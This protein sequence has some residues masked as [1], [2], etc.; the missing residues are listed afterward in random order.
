[1]GTAT[2][3]LLELLAELRGTS[4]LGRTRVLARAAQVLR[5][6]PA[7]ERR[8]VATE[9]ARRVA[10]ELLP[11]VEALVEE[12]IDPGQQRM[13]LDL[14]RRLDPDAVA[15][16]AQRLLDAETGNPEEPMDIVVDV[17]AGVD[18]HAAPQPIEL[19]EELHDQL[20]SLDEPLVLAL[21]DA[22]DE[23]DGPADEPAVPVA[24]V[25]AAG[26]A[27]GLAVLPRPTRDELVPALDEEPSEP[28]VD[29][30]AALEAVPDGWRRRRMALRFV[31][32]GQFTRETATKA[33]WLL[34]RPSDRVW[35]AGALLDAR[36]VGL[37]DVAEVVP[38]DALDRLARRRGD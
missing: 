37:A 4:R 33:L 29:V 7:G 34:G 36:V 3:E 21:E 32:R 30:L 19:V 28:P 20:P 9:M 22:L 8:A 18:G 12:R 17:T 27:A 1:M 2:T 26:A 6:M 16:V 13:L 15:D 10:P 5:G 31:T 35:L 38:R 25:A 11:H 24:P 14:T 23:P